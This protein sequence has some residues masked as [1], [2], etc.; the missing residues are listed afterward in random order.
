MR[1]E[2]EEDFS[3]FDDPYDELDYDMGLTEDEEYP[4]FFEEEVPDVFEEEEIK[5]TP[6]PG[7][8]STD[9]IENSNS[10]PVH[11]ELTEESDD[12]MSSDREDTDEQ[13]IELMIEPVTD[14]IEESD[15]SNLLETE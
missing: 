12:L 4:T 2:P 13:E 8:L 7:E 10:P 6:E 1:R 3:E 14:R 9:S 5:G 15:L 11:E